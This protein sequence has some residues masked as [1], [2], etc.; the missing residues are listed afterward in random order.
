MVSVFGD[1]RATDKMCDSRQK[2]VDVGEA[3]AATLWYLRRISL[4]TV[5]AFVSK[6]LADADWWNVWAGMDN[7]E[8]CSSWL[9]SC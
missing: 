4:V 6:E 1:D 3:G 9:D 7:I 5:K 2:N 8:T